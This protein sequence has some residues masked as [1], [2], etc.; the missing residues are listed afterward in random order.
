MQVVT[1][2]ESG[3]APPNVKRHLRP[4]VCGME[5]GI[6]LELVA[7]IMTPEIGLIAEPSLES[8]LRLTPE[9]VRVYPL[10]CA[11]FGPLDDWAGSMQA[12]LVSR[13]RPREQVPAKKWAG[14][15]VRFCGCS[16]PQKCQGSVLA[17]VDLALRNRPW[18]TLVIAVNKAQYAATMAY[19]DFLGR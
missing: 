18:H 15:I 19:E 7:R 11:P 16:F 12:G 4:C 3:K 14:C 9:W 8:R 6:Y 2:V 5:I 10:G 1:Q 13:H 17:N